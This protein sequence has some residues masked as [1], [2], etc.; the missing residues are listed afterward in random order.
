MF[1]KG[2]QVTK[3]GL[4]EEG[5]GDVFEV[6]TTERTSGAGGDHHISV[7]QAIHGDVDNP[8]EVQ[9]GNGSNV[10]E[11]ASCHISEAEE[12]HQSDREFESDT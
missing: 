9:V 5:T 4:A 3:F 10:T 2:L 12:G 11:E 6:G 1:S 7:Q 8:E